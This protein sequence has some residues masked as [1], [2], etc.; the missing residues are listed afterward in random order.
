MSW[1][2][3]DLI[4]AGPEMVYIIVDVMVYFDVVVIV[5]EY[6]IAFYILWNEVKRV[7]CFYLLLVAQW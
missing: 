3:C 2:G 1:L 5:D 4:L 6:Q 7:L